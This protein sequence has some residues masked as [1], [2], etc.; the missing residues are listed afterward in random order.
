VLYCPYMDTEQENIQKQFGKELKQRRE[1]AKLTQADVAEK[2]GVSVNYY[3]RIERGEEN[4]TL[5]KIQGIK[6]ALGIKS[7]TII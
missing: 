2:A 5:E 3:A 6:K 7:K 1:A 4:P